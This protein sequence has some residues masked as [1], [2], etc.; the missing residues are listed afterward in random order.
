MVLPSLNLQ[1]MNSERTSYSCACAPSVSSIKPASRNL[2]ITPYF[3]VC[4]GSVPLT[5]HVGAGFFGML[6]GLGIDYRARQL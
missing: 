3:F 6:N 5:E 2:I 1:Y 4:R